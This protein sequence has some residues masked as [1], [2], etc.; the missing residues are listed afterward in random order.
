M[1]HTAGVCR[2]AVLAPGQGSWNGVQSGDS[3]ER[4]VTQAASRTMLCIAAGA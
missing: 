2:F 1:P 3:R 4:A